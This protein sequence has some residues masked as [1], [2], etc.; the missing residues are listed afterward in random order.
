VLT[1]NLVMLAG[2][3]LTGF[4]FGL[5][6]RRWTGSWAAACVSASAAGF[7]AHLF[8][9]LGHLQAMHVEFVAVVLLGMDLVFTRQR[10]R[11]ALTLGVGFALQGLT[12]VYLLVFT[13]WASIFA[14]GCRMVLAARQARARALL[15]L[16]GAGLVAVLLMSFY[17]VAYVRLHQD[18]SF[19]RKA[20]DNRS[21]AGSYT[22]YLST[23][24]HLHYWWSRRFVDVSS[25]INFPGL[26]VLA[27]SAVALAHRPLRRDPR[28][29]MCASVAA[30]CAL[31]SMAARVPGYERIHNLVPLF[32]AVRVQ[33]HMGQVVLLA[34]SVLAGFGAWRL[35]ERWG[36]RRGAWLL[37]PAL[38]V[39]IN[40][41]VLRAPIPWRVFDGIPRVYDTLAALDRAVVIELPAYEGGGM[42]ANAAHMLN[43]TRHWH[44]LVNGYSGFAPASYA[45]IAAA[46]RSFPA[47]DAL[48]ALRTRRVTH[49]VIHEAAFVGHHGQAAFDEVA[50]TGS[51]HLL[52][53]EGDISIYRFR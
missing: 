16:T 28:V 44:P 49:V 12:S 41:E 8:T 39:V 50:R 43:S 53:R 19:A 21:F 3:V 47:Y 15:L 36:A 5:L 27:L 4:A 20:E 29:L 52:A 45:R 24:S 38:V 7:N 2:F 22:D 51:L 48:Q 23:V 34:L 25:S 1:F 40:A 31:A 26:A 17:L 46:M 18:Q 35:Q 14:A 9:R 42:M 10:V 6:V 32:W 37:A 11:D 33:A 30:G 13:T